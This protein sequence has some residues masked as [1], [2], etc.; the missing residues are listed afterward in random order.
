MSTTRDP[1]LGEASDADLGDEVR[2]RAMRPEDLSAVMRI[3]KASYSMPWGDG[4]FRGLLRRADSDLIVAEAAGQTVG[5]AVAWFV[6]DQAELG[7]VAVAQDWRGRGI[8]ALLLEEILDR[9]G[10]RGM[11]EIFLEVRPSNL[12]A[13]R[14]YERH[15]FREVGRRRHYYLEPSEDALVMRSPVPPPAR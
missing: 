8:G 6:V 15:G 14:L 1:R 11:R 5:Y 4:T 2:V 13:Q 12:V 10:R 3:E 9:A 7:N